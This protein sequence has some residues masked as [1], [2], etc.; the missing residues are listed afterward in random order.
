MGGKLKKKK[1]WMLMVCVRVLSIHDGNSA[2]Y[3]LSRETSGGI[4]YHRREVLVITKQLKLYLKNSSRMPTLLSIWNSVAE[5]N[6]VS[7]GVGK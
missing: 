6:L 5:E 2:Y 3:G 4:L 1:A 7:R